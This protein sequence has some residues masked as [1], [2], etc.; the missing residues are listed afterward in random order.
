M[1]LDIM[2]CHFAA[3]FLASFIV[4]TYLVEILYFG[5]FLI[6]SFLFSTTNVLQMN[7]DILGIFLC[8]YRIIR[9]INTMAQWDIIY[10]SYSD[11]TQAIRALL[12]RLAFGGHIDPENP[13]VE[14]DHFQRN[15]DRWNDY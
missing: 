1:D 4:Y 10:D 6:I 3:I 15:R 7:L 13:G 11:M 9:N 14:N 5:V 2:H 12:Q 8:D